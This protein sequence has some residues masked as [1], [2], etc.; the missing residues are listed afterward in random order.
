MPKVAVTYSPEVGGSSVISLKNAFLSVDWEICD[1]DYR[2]MISNIP[3]HQFE[4][5]YKTP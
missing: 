5:V 1:A 4:Q 3:N 2:K